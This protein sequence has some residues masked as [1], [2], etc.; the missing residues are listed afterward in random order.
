M[1]RD[2]NLKSLR[3]A[4][5]R[6]LFP[7]I[8]DPSWL[9]LRRRR[10]IFGRWLGELQPQNPKVLDVGGRLQPYRELLPLPHQYWSLDLS[11]SALVSAVGTAECLPFPENSF[12]VVICTQMLEYA[13]HPA[14][15][16]REIHRVLHPNGTLLLSAPSLFP[17]DSERDAWRFFPAAFRSLLAQFSEV[18]VVPEVGS[19][20]GLFRTVAA[21]THNSARYE[22]LRFL[23]DISFV[24]ILNLMG[25][26]ADKVM[27]SRDG[28]FTVNYSVRARK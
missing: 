26:V 21:F 27:G 3:E 23:L 25:A 1:C 16:V 6:R 9:V 14:Q 2:E 24:P 12:D 8:T 5:R 15:V 4:G 10:D 11:P 18:E 28:S 13:L 22:T 20:A 19:I 7:P 17:R